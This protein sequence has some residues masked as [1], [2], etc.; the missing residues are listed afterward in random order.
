VRPTYRGSGIGRELALAAI[1][2]ARRIGYSKMR[3]DTLASMPQARALYASLGFRRIPPYYHNPLDGA[4][5]LE[6]SLV[7]ARSTVGAPPASGWAV[8]DTGGGALRTI[9]DDQPQRQHQ[10]NRGTP[11]F[12]RRKYT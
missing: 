8:P 5:F 1:G 4:E 6:L 10:Q 3:L 12:A 2:E 11:E 9:G 7:D